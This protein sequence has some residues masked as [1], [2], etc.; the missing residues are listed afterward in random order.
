MIRGRIR[1]FALSVVTFIF[2]SA[3]YADD[4]SGMVAKTGAGLLVCMACIGYCMHKS[5][6][7]NLPISMLLLLFRTMLYHV[8]HL[9]HQ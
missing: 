3:I 7:W 2:V 8:Q 6:P 4:W 5:H 1:F 9:K